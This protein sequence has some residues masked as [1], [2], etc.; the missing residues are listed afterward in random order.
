MSDLKRGWLE[1]DATWLA[2]L[3]GCRAVGE[4]TIY[5]SKIRIRVE[6]SQVTE[7]GELLEGVFLNA[8][9]PTGIQQKR[10]TP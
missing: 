2:Q 1:V 8:L 7:E 4:V 3:F 5:L 10:I 6:S 9:V